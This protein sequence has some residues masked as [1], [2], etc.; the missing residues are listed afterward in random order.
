MRQF[1]FAEVAGARAAGEL[2]CAWDGL[3]V[4]VELLNGRSDAGDGEGEGDGEGDVCGDENGGW[5]GEGDG[6]GVGVGVGEGGRL[7]VR[8]Y[9][10]CGA[11]LRLRDS[12]ELRDLE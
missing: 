2:S 10:C 9:E 11:S 7:V 8:T 1:R 6:V 5:V 3:L 4:K 12:F